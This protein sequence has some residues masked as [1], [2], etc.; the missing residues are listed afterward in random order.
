MTTEVFITAVGRD[1]PGVIAG[2]TGALAGLDA[3]LEDTSMTTLG[4][5]FAMVLVVAVP[6]GTSTDVVAAALAEPAAALHLDVSVHPADPSDTA[7]DERGERWTVS[8]HGADHP[9]IV[10]GVTQGLSELGANVVD[11]RTRV[12]G[13]LER[14]VYV[15]TLEVSVPATTSAEALTARLDEVAAALGVECSLHPVDADIL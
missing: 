1:R 4:G 11:M 3:N 13:P 8:I 5:R 10:H 12:V 14:Q 9:G 7:A 2:L 15:M 6:E